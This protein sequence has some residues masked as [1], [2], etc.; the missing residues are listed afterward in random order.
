MG[1]GS[2]TDQDARKSNYKMLDTSPKH[3]FLHEALSKIDLTIKHLGETIQDIE[4]SGVDFS[5]RMLSIPPKELYK[6]LE[7]LKSR[8]EFKLGPEDI[9]DEFSDRY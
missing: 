5:G 9:P 7:N 2:S 8:I 3:R 4:K 6:E 1:H